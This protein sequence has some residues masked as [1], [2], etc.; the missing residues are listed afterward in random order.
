MNRGKKIEF[1]Y[2][3]ELGKR[4]PFSGS[5]WGYSLDIEGTGD[6]AEF[7]FD[8]KAREKGG[9]TITLEMLNKISHEA[10][11]VGKTGLLLPVLKGK[12]YIVLP[13]NLF[14]ALVR[15]EE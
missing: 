6:F 7:L 3:K 15:K 4:Q 1:K 10:M 13:L 2:A 8:T 12:P 11:I 5:K 14:K 9:L